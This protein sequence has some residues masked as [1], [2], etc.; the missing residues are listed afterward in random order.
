MTGS[1]CGCP[2]ALKSNACVRLITT[3]SHG[4]AKSLLGERGSESAGIGTVHTE[5]F[6]RH[7]AG[8]R[9]STPESGGR[10]LQPLLPLVPRLSQEPRRSCLPSGRPRPQ[11]RDGSSILAVRLSV[12]LLQ[13]AFLCDRGK[14][15]YEAKQRVTALE[16]ERVFPAKRDDVPDDYEPSEQGQRY[17]RNEPGL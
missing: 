5:L 11:S 3:L 1:R 4:R 13:P 7:G 16:S 6:G 17:S 10:R 14:D 8:G 15:V 2:S 12:L 9:R